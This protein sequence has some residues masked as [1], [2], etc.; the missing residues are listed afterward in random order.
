M[1][2][3]E[4]GHL[5][6]YDF[7]PLNID[8]TTH[9]NETKRSLKILQWNIERNYEPDAIITTLKKLD[10]DVMVLQEIDIDCRRSQSRN[11]MLE[12]CEAL[13]VKGG[14]V[15][16]FLELESS[17][18]RPRDQGGGIH[19]NAILSKHEISFNVI[20]H[21]YHGFDWDHHG[22]KLREP[23]KG[24]RYS[25]AATVRAP[26]LPPVLCYCLHLE[27]FTG[28]IDR[29]AN[30][31]EILQYASQHTDEIPHQIICGDLNTMAHSIARLSPKYATDRYRYL[32]LGETESSWWDR[33]VFAFHEQDGPVNSRL[34]TAGWLSRVPWFFIRHWAWL[35]TH[36]SGFSMDVLKKAR[37][38]GFY[39]PW[40][41]NQVT[42]ENP[43]YFGLF[44]AKL[45]WTLVRCMQV[46]HR[47]RGNEDYSASDHAYLLVEVVPDDDEQ[48]KQ[49]YILWKERRKQWNESGLLDEK[50]WMMTIVVAIAIAAY[51]CNN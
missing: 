14:F 2:T 17:I 29:V 43:D 18:R 39:D 28:I 45:D 34:A 32:S 8:D 16:E 30:F 1:A 42:L 6:T 9:I 23:R 12:L 10:A 21:R 15:C 4:P 47:S 35:Y 49:E 50:G 33:R 26:D 40:P 22:S 37:N 7:R 27:V 19:G 3:T 13:G 20:D 41:V 31:S 44:K 36:A 46:L 25:L 24:Q 48:V 51:F 38:P 11:H 5:L